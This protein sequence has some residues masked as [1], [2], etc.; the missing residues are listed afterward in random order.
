MLGKLTLEGSPGNHLV[1]LEYVVIPS[2]NISGA[3]KKLICFY[4]DE[5]F[6]PKEVFTHQ[7]DKN[8]AY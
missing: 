2:C 8:K 5:H 7:H 4:L 6:I 1:L 3:W